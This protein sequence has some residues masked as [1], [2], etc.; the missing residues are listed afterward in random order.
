MNI[1]FFHVDTHS[2]AS[3][4]AYIYAR[5][6]LR[7][8]KQCMPRVPV[9]MLTDLTSKAVKGVDD[10]RRKPLE[11]LALHR[12]RHHA[13]VSGD[14]LFVDTDVIFQQPVTKVFKDNPDFD[15]A[16]TTR[17][18]SHLKVASG[19]SARMPFN[20]G[21]VFS[22]R[23]SFW[24]EAYCRLKWLSPELQQWM[25]DQEVIGDIV[26][27]ESCG[28]RVKQL[29]GSKFN[30]PPATE[31][32]KPQNLEADAAIVH[33]KGPTRKPLLRQRIRQESRRCA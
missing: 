17:E 20:T 12:M 29:K 22:R 30:Y 25:G 15:I 14:W 31:T 32:V 8:A 33:Y 28:Y 11:P 9:V 16:V 1:G 19:F 21:V 2:D 7:S 6:M 4:D 13:S 23:P 3:S 26:T 24:Q 27:D 18:W 5:A 10:V